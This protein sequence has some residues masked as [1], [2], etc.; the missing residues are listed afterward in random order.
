MKLSQ[1][2]DVEAYLTTFERMMEA[3]EV[4]RAHWAF[5]LSPQLTGKAQQ[6]YAVLSAEDATDYHQLKAA[7][8]KRYNINEETYC[9]R[10]RTAAKRGNESH[11]ELMARL[12]DMARKWMKG[13]STVEQ[14]VDMVVIEQILNMMAPDVRIWVHERK[15]KSSEAAS[16]LAD[17]YAQARKMPQSSTRLAWGTRPEKR[18]YI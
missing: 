3:Y 7:I 11:Q 2:D 18:C 10:F 9:Q 12:Q 17:D 1:S 13:C 6:A 4:D 16:Q 5:K 8:L 14:V 15:P